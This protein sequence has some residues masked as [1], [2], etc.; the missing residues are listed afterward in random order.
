MT[1]TW[2]PWEMSRIRRASWNWPTKYPTGSK[3]QCP[4]CGKGYGWA[5]GSWTARHLPC[6][7]ELHDKEMNP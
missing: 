6:F 2:S 5:G 4:A 1:A 7:P 3:V